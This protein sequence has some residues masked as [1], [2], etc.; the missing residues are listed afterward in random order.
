MTY[1]YTLFGLNLAVPFPCPMLPPAP[2]GIEPD[3]TV[4]EGPVPF[5]LE[6][7]K[8]EIDN[9]QATPDRFLL[10][11]GRRS[12]RFLV[13]DGLR[14]ILQRN[15]NAENERLF[16]SLSTNVIGALLCQRGQLVLHAGVVMTPRGAVAISGES[17]AGKSTAQAALLARGCQMVADDVSVLRKS[18]D[19]QITVL[20]GISNINMCEDA[21]IKLGIDVVN[22]PRNPLRNIK[23]LVPVSHNCMITEPVP[24]KELYLLRRYPGNGLLTKRLTGSEKFLYLQECCYGPLFSEKHADL[25]EVLSSLADQIEMK[26]LDR[27][28]HGCSVDKVAEAILHG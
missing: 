5:S 18:D 25:F 23:V 8:V 3:V 21:A 13:E 14:I 20:P 16:M 26:V 17:G 1:Q 9:W 11:G 2:A 28:I 15:P 27:P 12:G 10:R 4:V 24:L 7:P 22:L 19:A 6:A